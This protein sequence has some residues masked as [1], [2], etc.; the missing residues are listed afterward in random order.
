MCTMRNINMSKT[1]LT[2]VH[3]HTFLFCFYRLNS[4]VLM[5]LNT[6]SLCHMLNY[7]RRCKQVGYLSN[8]LTVFTADESCEPAACCGWKP[9]SSN[10]ETKTTVD[11]FKTGR[12]LHSHFIATCILVRQHTTIICLNSLLCGPYFMYICSIIAPHRFHS[13]GTCL[14]ERTKR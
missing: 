7:E 1:K 8:S 5:C 9:K 12:K 13:A 4:D 10:P 6:S 11:G 3:L 14:W 2:R